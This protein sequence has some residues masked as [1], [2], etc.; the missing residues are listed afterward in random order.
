MSRIG[1]AMLVLGVAFLV[2]GPSVAQEKKTAPPVEKAADAKATEGK[3]VS[4]KEDKLTIKGADD[5]EKTFDVKGVKPTV[6]GKEGKWDDI[7]KDAKVTVTETDGKVT[8]VEAKN[9]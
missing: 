9:P 6:D 7:K 3:F 2:A 8:K 5:K 1:L 4:Y